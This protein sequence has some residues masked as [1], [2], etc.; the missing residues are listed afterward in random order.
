MQRQAQEILQEIDAEAVAATVQEDGYAVVPNFIDQDEVD[1]LNEDLAPIFDSVRSMERPGLG[2]QT[3]HIHNILGK[4]RA[5]D[6]IVMEPRLLEIVEAILGPD[7]QVSSIVVMCPRPG[8]EPQRLHR[9]DGHFPIPRVFPLVANSLLT[10]DPF[11]DENGATRIVP[12]SHLIRGQVD[13]ETD[14]VPIETGPGSLIIW[15]GAL[16][17]KGGGNRTENERRRSL[18][19]NFNLAWLKQRENQFLGV[20][21]ETVLELPEKLQQLMGYHLTNFGLGTVDLKHPLEYLKTRAF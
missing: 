1:K 12:R 13:V 19:L 15:D 8:D 6:H 7:F 21:K 5:V 18:N 17:H 16:W 14:T 10:L 20:S 3:V 2:Q 4:T 9:D 11:K